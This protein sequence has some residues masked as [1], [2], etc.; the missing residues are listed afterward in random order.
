MS[1]TRKYMHGNRRRV[2]S[3]L[4]D[5]PK[6]P[7]IPE[8]VSTDIK[9]K[10]FQEKTKKEITFDIPSLKQEFKP[11]LI[12]TP[13]ISIIPSSTTTSKDIRKVLPIGTGVGLSATYNPTETLSISGG[14]GTTN[15]PKEN[16][17]ILS[18][19][20]NL[21]K[22]FKKFSVYGGIEFVKD[23]PTTGGIGISK[24]F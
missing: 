5:T 19:G 6:T 13:S 14:I 4:L 22:K 3:P 8:T 9:S 21:T 16:I 17:S 24:T 2:S 15:I 10:M 11:S 20:I 1:R 23:R 7:I 12:T 18:G